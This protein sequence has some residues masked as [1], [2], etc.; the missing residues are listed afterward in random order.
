M[1]IMLSS[2]AFNL[3]WSKVSSFGEIKTCLTFRHP[4][5]KPF[6]TQ[7]IVFTCLEYQSLENTVRKGEIARNEQFLLFPQCFLSVWRTLCTFHCF[8]I[9]ISKL[10]QFGI[11]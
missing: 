11:V 5:F 3:D 1:Y 2:I 10:Y 9:V 4:L 6:P 7:A 8:K